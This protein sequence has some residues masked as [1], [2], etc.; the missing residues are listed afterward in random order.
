MET[1][2]RDYSPKGVRFYYVYKALAHPEHNN[3][4]TPFSLEERLMHVAEAERTLGSRI[5]WLADNM[6]DELKSALGGVNNAELVIGPD[7]RVLRRRAWSDPDELRKD[8]GELVGKVKRATRVSD[9]DLETASPPRTLAKGVVPRIEVPGAMRAL[10]IEP[11]LEGAEHPFYAKLRAEVDEDFLRSGEGKLYL[12]FHLDPLYHVHWNNLAEPLELELTAPEG[13]R[14][15]PQ[16]ATAPEVKEPADADPREFLLDLSADERNA[17]LELTVRYF[18]CDD[19]DTFCVP[20]S[21]SYRVHLEPDPNAGRVRERGGMGRG[22][23]GPGGPGGPGGRGPWG[24]GDPVDL[25]K[26]FDADGDGRITRDEAPERMKR[27]FDRID[28]DGDGAI[29][30]GEMQAIAE[31]MRQ[32]RGGR[33]SGGT[34][35]E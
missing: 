11:V 8:L 19:A 20:V 3:Y 25:L 1:V 13:V 31:R 14:V 6:A 7:G 4:V 28:I 26:R 34:S 32:R 2:E 30:A 23:G 12:G 5:P 29:D 27:R 9:L 22:R 16:K 24:G 21:Q 35:P 33:G 18:G 17:P 15:S 10:R